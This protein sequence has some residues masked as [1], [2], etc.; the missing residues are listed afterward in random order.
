MGVLMGLSAAG[1]A[2]APGNNKEFV[3]SLL[4]QK[5]RIHL[6]YEHKKEVMFFR[7]CFLLNLNSLFSFQPLVPFF[8]Y[9]IGFRHFASHH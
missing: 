4:S 5:I 9:H 8:L 2:T 7:K 6:Q 1:A 3:K